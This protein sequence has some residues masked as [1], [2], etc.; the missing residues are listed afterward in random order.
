MNLSD[1]DILELNELFGALVDGTATEKQRE[2]LARLLRDSEAARRCYVRAMGQSASLHLY[3][4]EMQSDAPDARPSRG[5]L[6]SFARWVGGALAVAAALAVGF[7]LFSRWASGER[8]VRPAT[9]AEFVARI[10]G[11]KGSEWSSGGEGLQPG[12]YLR[13]GQR[14]ELRAGYVEITFDSG[15]RVMLEGAASLDVNSAWDATLRRGTLKASVPPEAIGFRVS[16]P[17]VDVLDLG[18]EFTM[19]ADANGGAEVLVNKGEVEAAPRGRGEVEAILLREKEARRFAESGMS[20][21]T[22]RERKFALFTQ[23][24]ELQRLKTTLGY[25]HWSFDGTQDAFSADGP[26]SR[27]GASAFALVANGG[28]TVS[29]TES[30]HGQA[31][32]FDGQMFAKASFPGISSARPRTIAF[33]VRVPEDAQPVDTWMIAWGTTFPKLGYRPVHIGWNRRPG[34]GALGALRTDFGGGHAIGTT[35]LR[36]GKWHH[37]A[38][39]FAPGEGIDAPVQVKQY[40]DGRLDSSTIVPGVVRAPVGMVDATVEHQV[41]LGYRLTGHKQEGRRFR[42]ELDELFIADRG[43]QPHEIVSLMKDN[44]LPESPLTVHP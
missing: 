34:E 44:R 25:A 3:A 23:P 30:P 24:L 15:A 1:G 36:D 37:V 12:T 21:V 5:N 2:R 11:E 22:D 8:N 13:K 38:V 18:T 20:D 35:S 40:I 27:T 43:L 14:L 10:T 9:R 19:I 16:N 7:I 42:G 33:W 26:L 6:L 41:W 31:L 29:L 17:F 39:Y 28:G 32:R 4:A